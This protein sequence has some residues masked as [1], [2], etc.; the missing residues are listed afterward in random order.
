MAV[1]DTASDPQLQDL[2]RNPKLPGQCYPLFS[3]LLFPNFDT[4]G[5]YPFQ[6]NPLV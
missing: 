3:H 1:R 2:L 4:E 5:T 6:C